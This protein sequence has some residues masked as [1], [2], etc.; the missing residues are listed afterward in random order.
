MIFGFKQQ[1]QQQ[2]VFVLRNQKVFVLK[3]MIFGFKQQQQIFVLR[4]QKSFLF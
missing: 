2:Q 3:K 4:N 1:Q